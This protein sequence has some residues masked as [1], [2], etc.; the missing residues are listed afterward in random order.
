MSCMVVSIH[1]SRRRPMGLGWPGMECAKSSC[2]TMTSLGLRAA[3][4]SH[5]TLCH[6]MRSAMLV[7]QTASSGAPHPVPPCPPALHNAAHILELRSDCH[8]VGSN[9]DRGG[10]GGDGHAKHHCLCLAEVDQHALLPSHLLQLLEV[11]FEVGAVWDYGSSTRS[12]A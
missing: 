12:S 4:P 8:A 3:C 1:V 5:L 10:S 9:L 2:L 6:L 7:W 11:S